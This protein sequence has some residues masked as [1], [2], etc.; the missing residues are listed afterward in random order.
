MRETGLFYEELAEG[1]EFVSDDR[2]V[3]AADIRAFAELS[4]D[5]NA[6][7]LDAAAARA[8]GFDAPIAHGALGLSLATGL[9]SRLGITRGTLIA[10]AGL[11]WRF[12]RPVMDGD[13]LRLYLTVMA[14]RATR[15]KDRGLVTLAA[16]LVNQR[17]ETVQEGELLELVRKRE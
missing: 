13:T 14:R 2:A 3:T 16:R 9:A 17:G 7:H 12:L 6:I 15:Q 8:A 5:H 4:G 11:T 1:R 10:L